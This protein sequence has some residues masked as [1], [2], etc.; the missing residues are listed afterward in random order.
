[1]AVYGI[2]D[3]LLFGEGAFKRSGREQSRSLFKAKVFK[4]TLDLTHLLYLIYSTLFLLKD[5]C[6]YTVTKFT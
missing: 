5:H 3:V 2:S 1:M 4:F 6:I